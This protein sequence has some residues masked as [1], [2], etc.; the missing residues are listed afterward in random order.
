VATFSFRVKIFVAVALLS[1][2]ALLPAC[3]TVLQ[4]PRLAQLR[5]QRPESHTCRSCH[6]G[7]DLWRYTH[8]A[9]LPRATGVW[10][11]YYDVPWWFE[12]HWQTTPSDSAAAEPA[13][14]VH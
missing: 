1:A 3:Y 7:D 4:H 5:Y 8:P 14:E 11:D 2:T 13:G 10:R 9:A 12:R 6:S